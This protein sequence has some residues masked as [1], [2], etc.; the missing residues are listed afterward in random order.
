[1]SD[2]AAPF[3]FLP[4]RLRRNI[5]GQLRQRSVGA[6]EL[7]L[8]VG[9]RALDVSCIVEGRARIVL[10]SRDGREVS[11]RELGP[12]DVFGELAALDGG[13][14]S[15]SIVAVTPVTL[16]VLP[17]ADF[18]SC[19]E[20]APAVSLGR[21]RRLGAEVRRLTERLFELSALNAQAKLHCELLR[22]AR[23]AAP[24]TRLSPA[25]THEELA[26]RIGSHRE[27]VTRELRRLARL[28]VI[29]TG[30]RR[31]AFLDLARLETAVEAL[32][33]RKTNG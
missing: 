22:L 1:M 5:S 4:P 29:E 28:G 3:S 26:N 12:G 17:R 11:V 31:L 27:A 14:R 13:P 23:L 10:H 21:A 2:R 6:G 33:P 19:R 7:L 20:A 8:A 25:P 15:A 16:A 30:H 18:L 32:A 24:A 9:T